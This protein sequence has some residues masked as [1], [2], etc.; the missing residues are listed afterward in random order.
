MCSNTAAVVIQGT[1]LDEQQSSRLQAVKSSCVQT[2]SQA[3]GQGIP[4]RKIIFES[5]T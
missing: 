3:L 2:S 1:D 4:Y 5:R